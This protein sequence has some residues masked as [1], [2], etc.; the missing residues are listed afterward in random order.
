MNFVIS[1]VP[2]NPLMSSYHSTKI[3]IDPISSHPQIHSHLLWRQRMEMEDSTSS[4]PSH[5][6]QQQMNQPQQVRHSH[7]PLLLLKDLNKVPCKN[8]Y[9]I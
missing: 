4:L 3:T 2:T 1:V 6:Q 5:H 9:R 8:I 7:H